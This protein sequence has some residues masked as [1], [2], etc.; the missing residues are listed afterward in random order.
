VELISIVNDWTD[1]HQAAFEKIKGA[2]TGSKVLA[3]ADFSRTFI[4]KTDAS[5]DGLGAILSQKQPDG[6]VRVIAYGL[7][8]SERNEANYSSFKLEMLALT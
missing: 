1:V 4:L 5:F 6:T 2:L 8:P 7:R 3:F